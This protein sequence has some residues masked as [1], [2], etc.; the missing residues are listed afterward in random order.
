MKSVTI[1]LGSL[2]QESWLSITERTSGVLKTTRQWLIT[3][4]S[5]NKNKKKCFLSHPPLTIIV[6]RNNMPAIKIKP[7]STQRKATSTIYLE[8]D[9]QV[10]TPVV[11]IVDGDALEVYTG[12]EAVEKLAE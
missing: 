10:T 6:K 8:E 3:T 1:R 12:Q 9:T 2:L 5:G 4:L 7:K 11:V